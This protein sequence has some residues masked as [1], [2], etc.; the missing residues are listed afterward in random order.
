[1]FVYWYKTSGYISRSSGSDSTF[2]LNEGPVGRPSVTTRN[3][4]PTCTTAISEYLDIEL[5]DRVLNTLFHLCLNREIFISDSSP[6]NL[7]R[8]LSVDALSRLTCPPR[9]VGPPSTPLGTVA[10]AS[11]TGP[12]SSWVR[13]ITEQVS[14]R[15]KS[16]NENVICFSIH[17]SL[18]ET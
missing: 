16:I 10:L 6:S 13:H 1:M 14:G 5:S 9:V 15:Y 2:T 11:Y 8:L 3:P 17:A 12:E 18:K 4:T 7:E